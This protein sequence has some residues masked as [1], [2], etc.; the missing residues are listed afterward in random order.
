[1]KK[2]IIILVILIGFI[3]IHSL[4]F[5]RIG[6]LE[7][8]KTKDERTACVNIQ[9]Y[10]GEDMGCELSVKKLVIPLS[11]VIHKGDATY[12]CKIVFKKSSLSV[13]YQYYRV[14]AVLKKV[15]VERD[16]IIQIPNDLKPSYFKGND[17]YLIISSGLEEGDEI[18]SFGTR[19]P[20]TEI[21]R[22]LI[23]DT[24]N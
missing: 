9:A 5:P 3:A 10:K 24:K 1:M 20:P 22:C 8:Y 15:T 6:G 19:F 21:T 7:I 11:S 17:K 4:F 12:V 18:E 13:D 14:L 23:G 2:T 16:S